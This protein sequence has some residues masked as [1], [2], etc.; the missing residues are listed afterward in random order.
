MA[1]PTVIGVRSGKVTDRFVGA[2]DVQ[3]IKNFL[4]RLESQ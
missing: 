4:Q 3:F 1:V 2:Q